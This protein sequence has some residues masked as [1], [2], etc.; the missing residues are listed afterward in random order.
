MRWNYSAQKYLLDLLEFEQ[1]SYDG[2]YI[3][4]LSPFSGEEILQIL[5]LLS[6][7]FLFLFA[8]SCFNRFD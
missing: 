8:P 2:F 4:G 5:T 3:K 6:S 7:G 1:I